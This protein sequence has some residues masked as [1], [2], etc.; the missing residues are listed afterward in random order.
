MAESV[1]DDL[2]Y[3]QGTA[4]ALI[5]TGEG[6]LVGIFV[7][8]STSGT[9]KAWDNTSAATTVIFDTTA[10]ITAPAFLAC[11]CNFETGLYITVGGTIAYTVCW[12]GRD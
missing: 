5:R 3:T 1:R 9:L 2:K 6:Y 11:P 8:S 7:S 10:A 4:S 12:G